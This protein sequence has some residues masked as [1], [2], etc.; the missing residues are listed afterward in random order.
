M[1]GQKEQKP[2]QMS[3]GEILRNYREAKDKAEQIKILAQLNLCSE[4]RIKE[5]LK[6]QGVDGR[7]LPRKNTHSQPPHFLHQQKRK[8]RK[9]K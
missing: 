6:E 4:E 5:I 8:R 9:T 2:L 1:N 3:E 7:A